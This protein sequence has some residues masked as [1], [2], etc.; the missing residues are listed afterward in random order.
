MP[1][2][3]K[4]PPDWTLPVAPTP[5]PGQ[6]WRSFLRRSAPPHA[7]PTGTR[8]D[9]ARANLRVRSLCNSWGRTTRV[10]P[11]MDHRLLRPQ[12][13]SRLW[14]RAQSGYERGSAARCPHRSVLRSRIA[15]EHFA[16]WRD[17]VRLAVG[18]R[19]CPPTRSSAAASERAMLLSVAAPLASA[20]SAEARE[21]LLSA[22]CAEAGVRI[23]WGWSA[24][25]TGESS[26]AQLCRWLGGLG[27]QPFR[28][29][30]ACFWFG[31]S[32]V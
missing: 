19:R 21:S 20:K 14:D 9:L 26:P 11:A 18:L 31:S 16:I 10:A 6:S 22:W 12:H 29:R 13:P 5:V 1:T 27:E 4:L 23:V 25:S 3:A 32:R 30:P 15:S 24:A 8:V 7:K 17:A 2:V 28:F